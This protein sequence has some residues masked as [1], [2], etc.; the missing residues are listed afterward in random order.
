MAI[1]A[2]QFSMA[3][4]GWDI[5]GSTAGR[6]ADHS[7]TV[8][9]QMLTEVY[10]AA[11]GR[12]GRKVAVAIAG[13]AVVL[14]L[15]PSVSMIATSW[16]NRREAARLLTCVRKIHPGAISERET[17]RE[18]S[19]FDRYIF[20]GQESILG[21]P[22]ATR[23]SY[24][25]S[26]YP[27][28]VAF[29][30]PH[31]SPWVNENIWFLPYT[32]FSVS[33]RFERGELVLL[34]VREFQEHRGDIHPYAAIVRVLSIRSEESAPERPDGFTGYDVSPVE[35][36]EFDQADKQI[37][38]SWISRV[39]VTLDE[40]ASGEQFARSFDFRLSCFTS[41][42]GCHDAREILPSVPMTRGRFSQ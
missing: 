18:L 30:A 41:L 25:I 27:K 13:A 5:P 40:R 29:V 39:Y 24:S 42:P 21:R 32:H 36:A 28:W 20:H 14:L 7:P 16:W 31:L 34:E 23:D 6:A 12:R 9:A 33:P 10:P 2:I 3:N 35:E 11:M 19:E 4:N 38:S 37:G 26:N 1:P 15:A 8:V 22:T 17:R